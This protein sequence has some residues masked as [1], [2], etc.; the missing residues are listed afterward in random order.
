MNLKIISLFGGSCLA[1]QYLQE[2]QKEP[3]ESQK[4]KVNYGV[5]VMTVIMPSTYF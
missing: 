3:L 2:Y 1:A 5:L 4:M